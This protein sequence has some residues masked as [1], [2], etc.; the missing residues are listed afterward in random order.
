M[1]NI[2]KKS[3]NTKRIA[4]WN[5]FVNDTLLLIT[6]KPECKVFD[7][8]KGVELIKEQYHNKTFYRYHKDSKRIAESVIKKHCERC[9]VL[10]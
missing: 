3:E 8:Y 2:P 6:P 7:F 5:A 9:N 4:L 1:K 10:F